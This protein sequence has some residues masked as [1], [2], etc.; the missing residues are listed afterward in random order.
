MSRTQ[1]P[2]PKPQIR[3]RFRIGRRE[4][5]ALRKLWQVKEAP[6]WRVVHQCG[7]L[8][9]AADWLRGH[10]IANLDQVP[11]LTSGDWKPLSWWL[12]QGREP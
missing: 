2:N 1:I 3:E 5:R 4:G 11:V 12:E 10:T 6:G 8:L 7:S 9:E